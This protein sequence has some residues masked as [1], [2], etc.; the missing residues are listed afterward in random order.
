MNIKDI[1][2]N[3]INFSKLKKKDD[4]K[5][6]L[7]YYNNNSLS[8]SIN[9]LKLKEFS[10]HND[11]FILRF[12]L[13]DIEIYNFIDNLNKIVID[14]IYHNS[15]DIFNECYGI[16]KIKNL[17]F[18]N[19]YTNDNN[20]YITIKSKKYKDYLINEIMNINLEITGIWIYEKMFGISFIE[21][22]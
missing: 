21:Q 4:I 11:E 1:N 2:I 18:T 5:Y 14:Y 22:N 15:L 20:N 10:K 6:Y 3:T 7:I 9:N 19:I 13:N 16:E 17:F 8:I 12:Y